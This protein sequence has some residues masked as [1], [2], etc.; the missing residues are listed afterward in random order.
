MKK[1]NLS[2]IAII[3]SA[4]CAAQQTGLSNVVDITIPDH[5][6]KLDKN[7]AVAHSKRLFKH[8]EIGT[9]KTKNLY[10]VDD[11]TVAFWDILGQNDTRT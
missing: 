9:L 7:N 6:E 2:I 1:I 11:V 4:T 3:I 5:A 8:S 10:K